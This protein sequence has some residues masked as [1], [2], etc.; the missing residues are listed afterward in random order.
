[1]QAR[2]RR[3]QVAAETKVAA[4]AGH[5]KE[6]E[7]LV[8]EGKRIKMEIG[9]VEFELDRVSKQLMLESAKIPNDTCSESKQLQD[10]QRIRHIQ[11]AGF[12]LCARMLF[13]RCFGLLFLL[14]GRC[15]VANCR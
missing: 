9:E 6:R 2:H 12:I 13:D 10:M 3:N 4:Q 14:A 1:M 11:S 15:V 7:A 8:E 5:S